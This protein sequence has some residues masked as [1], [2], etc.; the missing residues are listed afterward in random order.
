MNRFLKAWSGPDR[1]GVFR[2]ARMVRKRNGPESTGPCAM[3]GA[4]L[5]A[6]A[7]RH[8]AGRGTAAGTA[9]KR[10]HN[11]RKHNRLA[12]RV[13]RNP[14]LPMYFIGVSA[15]HIVNARVIRSLQMP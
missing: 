6:T 13:K 8:R 3:R 12:E 10:A 15:A 4:A 14:T 1:A 5:T 11:G 7:T 2:E 9:D